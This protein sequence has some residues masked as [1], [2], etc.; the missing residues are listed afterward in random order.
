MKFQVLFIGQNEI[1]NLER[2]NSKVETWKWKWKLER[3]NQQGPTAI[4]FQMGPTAINWNLERWNLEME[5]H[6]AIRLSV[7]FCPSQSG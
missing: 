2:C 4:N 1:G 5:L 6:F 3:C 7:S